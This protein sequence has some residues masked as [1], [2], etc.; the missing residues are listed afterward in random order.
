MFLSENSHVK[1][2]SVLNMSWGPTNASVKGR[3][4]CA[5]SWRIR[6][7]GLLTENGKTEHL[8]SGDFLYM[9]KEADYHIRSGEEEILVIHFDLEGDFGHHMEV[10]H[11]DDPNLA[12]NFTELS[13]VWN[14]KQPGYYFHALSLF[15]HIVS[16]LT[17]GGMRT[18][19]A[20]YGRIREAAEYLHANYT[21][22]ELTVE[23]LCR[24]A[25]MSDTY[26]RRLFS[27]V[28]GETPLRYLNR[29][30]IDHAK[31]LLR[32]GTCGISE[33]AVRSGF[34]DSKYF[35]TVFRA[36]TG[37]TPSQYRG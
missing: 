9:P 26:F 13:K 3:S 36:H 18:H 11:P 37:C 25:F 5:L 35:S 33:V 22:P 30:R 4:V 28:Y 17:A 16:G 7:D 31:A 21:A 15:Y 20:Q 14:Q 34:S 6:G 12:R 27:H 2:I 29:L 10:F 23:V 24:R 8:K 19:S 1:I 32:E